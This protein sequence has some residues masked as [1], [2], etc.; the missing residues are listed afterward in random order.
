MSHPLYSS[1]K[2]FNEPHSGNVF[3]NNLGHILHFRCNANMPAEKRKQVCFWLHGYTAHTNKPDF[4]RYSDI[5]NARGVV[6]MGLD[7][8]GHGHSEGERALVLSHEH[9]VQDLCQFIH[10]IYEDDLTHDQCRLQTGENTDLDLLISLKELPFFLMGSSMGGAV[11]VLTSMKVYTMPKFIGCTLLAPFLGNAQLP[12][13]LLVEFFKYTFAYWTP[14]WHMP[15]FLSNVS[16]N[17]LTWTNEEDIILAEMDAWGNEG[18]LGF[19]QGMKW[20]TANMF[21]TMGPHIV[22]SFK[23]VK[24]P[25]LILHDPADEICAIGGSHAMMKETATPT[26]HKNLIEVNGFL[27]GMI[28]NNPEEVCDLVVDWINSRPPK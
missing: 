16:D 10:H 27:H 19:G 24:Y 20:G 2:E 7:M 17:S 5:M 18:G 3:V 22:E 9:L 4:K 15:S 1:A 8:Q 23:E 21:L 26:E 25:F 12:H 14:N 13:W 6:V 11:S 28:Y